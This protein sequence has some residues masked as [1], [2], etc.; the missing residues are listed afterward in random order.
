VRTADAERDALELLLVHDVVARDLP[1]LAICRGMQVLN[2]ALGGSLVQDI[3]TQ[4]PDAG[5]HAVP[6]SRRSA[7]HALDVIGPSHLREAV[8]VGMSRQVN[9]RHHQ[10]VRTL[11]RSLRVTATAPDGV[12]EAIE[13]PEAAFCVGVQWHPENFWRTGEMRP[14]FALFTEAAGRARTPQVS[15]GAP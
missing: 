8:D 13:L 3:P 15:R 14:L 7:A 1:L 10:A 2:V 5:P 6:D 9:S 12:I 4:C 11:G